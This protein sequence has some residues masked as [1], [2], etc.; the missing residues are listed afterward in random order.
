MNKTS[1][2]TCL[3][4]NLHGTNLGGRL[5]L[6]GRYYESL[7]SIVKMED[8]DF[9]LFTSP[10]EKDQII[11]FLS[12]NNISNVT[13]HAHDLQDFYMNDLFSLYKDFEFARTESQRCQEI[14]Y[15]KTFWCQKILRE[16]PQ[17]EFC[18]WIDVGISHSGL[19]PDKYMIVS[20]H[21]AYECFN[22]TLYSNNLITGLN[23]VSIN[24]DKIFIIR[25]HNIYS[26][27]TYRKPEEWYAAN[28][29]MDDH[30]TIGGIFGGSR[31]SMLEF[32]SLFESTARI[33]TRDWKNVYDEECIYQFIFQLLPERFNEYRFDTWY[34]E[35]NIPGVNT[36]EEHRKRLYE[37]KSFYNILEEIHRLVHSDVVQP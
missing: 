27:Y 32:A 6:T 37:G 26:G 21:K 20:D 11:S 2:V 22:N 30:H 15:N 19:V 29:D 36:D 33:I 34:H 5:G 35:D 1:I 8:A 16:Y 14:Q 10:E 3:Y 7:K 24:N 31:I 17:Y 4:D 28:L 18:Y 13:V 25:I 9:H 23:N 12:E